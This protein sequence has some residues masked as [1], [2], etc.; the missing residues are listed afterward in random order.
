MYLFFLVIDRV[1]VME[2]LVLLRYLPA[3]PTWKHPR[4][5]RARLLELYPFY[6]RVDAAHQN[7][8]EN[9]SVFAIAVFMS[10]LTKVNVELQVGYDVWG[11][12]GG[13]D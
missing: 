3:I 11:W 9:M 6:N 12:V 4:I 10:Y 13:G 1:V 7:T 2:L 5:A 8:V